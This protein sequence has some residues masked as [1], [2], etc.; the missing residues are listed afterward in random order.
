MSAAMQH[1]PEAPAHIGRRQVFTL[2]W[3]IVVSMLFYTAMTIVDVIVVG[4]LGTSSLAA[5]GLA[6][7]ICFGLHALGN[8]LL[9]GLKVAVAQAT[10]AR[11]TQD[12][13]R[14]AIQGLW[15]A[16]GMGLA[17]AAVAPLSRSIFG[18]T[19]ASDAVADE[20]AA[21]LVIRAL[22]APLTFATLAL[23]SWFQGRGDTRTPMIANIGAN[24][25]NIGL[26]LVLVFGWGPIPAMGIAGAAIATQVGFA[27]AVVFLVWR[28]RRL[29][30]GVPRGFDRRLVGEI[31]RVGGP[32]G[33]RYLFDVLSFTI[34]A[35]ILAGVGD[36]DLAAHTVIIRI[37]CVSFLPGF[38]IAQAASIL[39]GQSVGA[40][41]P[42]GAY[43]AHRAGTELAVAF[44]V[45][46]GLVFVAVPEPLI[47]IFGA[48]PAVVEVAR[49]LLLIA[50][51]FQL[52][53]ALA[54]VAQSAL[55][56]A[57]DTR[58]VMRWSVMMAWAVK[59][60]VGWALAV[61]AGLGAPGAWLGL[62]AEIV[63]VGGVYLWRIRSGRWLGVAPAPAPEVRQ[64]LA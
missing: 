57:G 62:T 49:H 22:G 24:L 27:G 17:V 36:A 37:V 32:I 51:G 18:W 8:G 41:R 34:F 10:G 3:P 48:E 61:P 6:T 7:T 56:G 26:D 31:R 52:F 38:G 21:Y 16:L 50:A 58:F 45:A 12:A 4:Q 63:L 2:A 19:G 39:V 5:I 46:C 42:E 9:E 13:D 15:L 59:L 43:A 40:G 14:L 1:A 47:A 53:D 29:L 33:L 35:S 54:T 28:A 55:N 23:S 64:A 44:M 60:P 20:A 30:V 11:R 25:A